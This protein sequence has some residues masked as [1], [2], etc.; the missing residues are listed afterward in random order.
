VNHLEQSI[1]QPDVA[2]AFVYC[3]YK[4]QERQ[5]VNN[6]LASLVQQLVQKA[7][8]I[9]DDVTSLFH[10]HFE[11]N[12]H[13]TLEELSTLLQLEARRFSKVF[14]IIDA[15]DEC[16]EKS[17]TRDS[18]LA[19]IRKLQPATNLLITSRNTPPDESGFEKA[20]QLEIHATD[21]DVRK[22]LEDRIKSEGRLAR[23]IRTDRAFQ[24]TIIDTIVQ[25]AKGMYVP[26]AIPV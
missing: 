11:K 14:I 18:F 17:G 4:E 19:E 25:N 13:P 7:S 8:V 24:T 16:S 21:D 26:H 9:S 6:L 23:L 3:S 12:T 2:I 5:T 22:Y 10:R 1:S 20:T 15:L